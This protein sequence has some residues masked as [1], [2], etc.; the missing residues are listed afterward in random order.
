MIVI[1][2]V[3]IKPAPQYSWSISSK[4]KN[5]RAHA[6]NGNSASTNNKTKHPVDLSTLSHDALVKLV[7]KSNKDA[8]NTAKANSKLKK[9]ADKQEAEI[10]KLR[11]ETNQLQVEKNLE[12]E[13]IQEQIKTLTDQMASHVATFEASTAKRTIPQTRNLGGQNRR[14]DLI[15][16]AI[17]TSNRHAYVTNLHSNALW[18]SREKLWCILLRMGPRD[19]L[20]FFGV[21]I[22][23]A[24]RLAWTKFQR[25]FWIC[26]SAKKKFWQKMVGFPVSFFSKNFKPTFKFETEH[27]DIFRILGPPKKKQLFV[28]FFSVKKWQETW[29][30]SV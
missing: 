16:Q 17:R 23:I 19:R 11:Q 13:K 10:K 18:V 6:T 21:F 26:L 3:T 7:K 24:G 25:V 28:S 20:F 9:A 27:N 4:E 1:L 29:V 8:Q 5:R 12:V 22:L 15:E 14:K 2:G 30:F